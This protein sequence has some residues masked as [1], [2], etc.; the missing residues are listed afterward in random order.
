M[1]SLIDRAR[2]LFENRGGEVTD[3][4]LC[5]SFLDSEIHTLYMRKIIEPVK[6]GAVWRWVTDVAA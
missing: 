2:K 3:K 5:S 6:K 1:R 4:E